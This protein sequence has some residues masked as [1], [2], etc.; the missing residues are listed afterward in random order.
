MGGPSNS[1]E[2]K[3]L[4]IVTFNPGPSNTNSAIVVLG[5]SNETEQNDKDNNALF[6]ININ[7]PIS[8]SKSNSTSTQILNKIIP[9]QSQLKN[10]RK[11]RNLD[12]EDEEGT[13]NFN[14]LNETLKEKKLFFAILFS[15]VGNLLEW[16]DYSLFASFTHYIGQNFFPPASEKTELLRSFLIHQVFLISYPSQLSQLL[17]S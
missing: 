5:D 14:K 16:Y 10:I 6:D 12:E 13:E 3:N 15:S 9:H 1:T 8:A 7:S 11:F 17:Y 2:K 4:D